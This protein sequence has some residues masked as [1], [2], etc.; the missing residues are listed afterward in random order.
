VG[1]SKKQTA[2][3]Q[4]IDIRRP[5]VGVSAQT[6]HPIGHIID[7]DEQDIGT[8]N[9]LRTGESPARQGKRRR[10][11]T[12]TL[13]KLPSFHGDRST[14]ENLRIISI[15]FFISYIDSSCPF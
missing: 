14:L 2:V 11:Q 10:R 8:P 13:E 4:T 3:G 9:R 15:T 7:S 5:D 12:R 6:A 1:L